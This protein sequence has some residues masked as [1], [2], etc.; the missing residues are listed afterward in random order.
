MRSN[1][2]KKSHWDLPLKK[3]CVTDK[4]SCYN[5]CIVKEKNVINFIFYLGDS[6]EQPR[7]RPI[8]PLPLWLN[9]DL[10]ST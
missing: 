8:A 6:L 3:H 2:Q 7:F 5:E 4:S 9:T 1:D 10:N